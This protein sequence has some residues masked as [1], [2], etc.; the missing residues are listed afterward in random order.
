[1]TPWAI[2]LPAP[3]IR[4]INYRTADLPENRKADNLGALVP[5]ATP[6]GPATRLTSPHAPGLRGRMLWLR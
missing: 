1:M 2:C 3:A 6:A 4:T 5:Q